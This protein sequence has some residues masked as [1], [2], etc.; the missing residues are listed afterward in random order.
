MCLLRKVN[1]KLKNGHIYFDSHCVH[2]K[3]DSISQYSAVS[4]EVIAV[5]A[6]FQCKSQLFYIFASLLLL[7]K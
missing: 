4:E 2:S 3:L 5:S 7:K 6:C 1:K